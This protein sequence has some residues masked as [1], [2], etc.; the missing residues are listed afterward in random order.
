MNQKLFDLDLAFTHTDH[1][2]CNE[3]LDNGSKLLLTKADIWRED[4][5]RWIQMIRSE[6]TWTCPTIVREAS[7]ISLGL[8][9]TDDLTIRELNTRW[10]NKSEKT[11]VLSFP[12]LDE[13]VVVPTNQC[14]ELGDIV[15]S[16]TTAQRQALEQNHGLV[17]EIRWLVSHGLLHLLGWDHPS[18]ATLDEMMNCQEQLLR[19]GGNLQSG[20]DSLS[21]QL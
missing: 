20:G 3:A 11:D 10:R 13:A 12:V 18:Q 2:A 17:Q 5:I 1:F 19:V 16:V 7:S 15:V 9:L 4:L 8:Q 14:V 6:K 21:K